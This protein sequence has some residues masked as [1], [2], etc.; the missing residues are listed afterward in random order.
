LKPGNILLNERGQPLISDFGT[1]RIET[2]DATPT[3][4]SGSIHYAAPELYQDEAL[5]TAKC[6][7]FS[8]GLIVYE[9]IGGSPVFHPDELPFPII[10]RL[11][12]MDLP[13]VPISWYPVMQK[14]IPQCW[15]EN[16]DDRP[17]FWEIFAL[18]QVHNFELLSGANPGKIREFCRGVLEWERKAGLP[19]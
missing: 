17:S 7:V 1:S 11:R 14:V 5:L 9:I 3:A 16:P 18:F 6:D 8:F 4:E 12:A 13:A 15:R 10:R 2:D 19:Q